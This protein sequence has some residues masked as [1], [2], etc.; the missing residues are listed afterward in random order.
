MLEQDAFS[1]SEFCKRNNIS[2][3]TYYNL[4]KKGIGPRVIKI[5]TRTIISVE[6][7]AEWRRMMEE[8]AAKQL[9]K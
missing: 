3:A 6:A 2:R 5:G 1:I 7:G 8:A 9:G 4:Q